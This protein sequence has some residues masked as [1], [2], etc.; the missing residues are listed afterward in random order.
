MGK[1]LGECWRI[2][3]LL[4]H[5]LPFIEVAAEG[6]GDADKLD[7]IEAGDSLEA[8]LGCCCCCWCCCW[9]RWLE[10]SWLLLLEMMAPRD[11][12]EEHELLTMDG[13]VMMGR[14]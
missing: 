10:D 8:Y 13:E 14:R 11:E 9:I 3:P 2:G 6:K 1:A 7:D 12:A 5:M 4:V